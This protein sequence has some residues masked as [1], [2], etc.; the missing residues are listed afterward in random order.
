MAA[1]AGQARMTVEE[2]VA[3]MPRLPRDTPSGWHGA[4]L[5]LALDMIHV[6]R[7][8]VVGRCLDEL[9]RVEGSGDRCR[10]PRRRDGLTAA[11]PG[12][13]QSRGEGLAVTGPAGGAYQG[14]IS[15][16][17]PVASVTPRDIADPVAEG[18]GA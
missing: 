2:R 12:P 4:T 11:R 18:G 16:E 6:S 3:S 14:R 7:G 5:G 8:M 9:P 13:T 15:D 17:A 1:L 10:T